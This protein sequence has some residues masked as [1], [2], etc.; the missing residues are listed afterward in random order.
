MSAR[1]LASLGTLCFFPLLVLAACD[2]GGRHAQEQLIRVHVPR[3]QE[4]VREDIERGVSGVEQAA[5]KL[6][7]LAIVRSESR[8][9]HNR[10]WTTARAGLKIHFGDR[11]PG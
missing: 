9:Q 5:T 7:Y 11:F 3:V 10:A 4:I 2:D 8:W 1:R 6:I